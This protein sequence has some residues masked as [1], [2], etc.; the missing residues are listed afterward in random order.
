M[1]KPFNDFECRWFS[2]LF[3]LGYTPLVVFDIGASNGTW[4]S[5]LSDVLPNT[6]FEMFEPL[7]DV[8]PEYKESLDQ[9]LKTRP[10]LRIHKIGLSDEVSVLEMDIFRDGFSSSFINM[11]DYAEVCDRKQLPV[12]R[13][14]DYVAAEGL[15][16]PS[17]VKIDVQGFETKVIRG[18]RKTLARA[19]IVQIESWFYRGYGPETPTISETIEQMTGLGHSLVELGE[20]FFDSD[21]RLYAIDAFFFRNG[22]AGELDR[23]SRGASW[24]MERQT[25][26]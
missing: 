12:T 10:N 19:D 15:R 11:G 24:R 25:V 14:D 4:S 8:R 16:Q 7:A 26:I 3:D 21:N 23:I 9:V 18:A 5:I 2:R 20:P 17:I 1:T 22:F 6:S 13:L